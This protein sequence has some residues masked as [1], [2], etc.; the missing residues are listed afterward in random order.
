MADVTKTFKGLKKDGN[1]ALVHTGASFETKDASTVQQLSPLTYLG[2]GTIFEL[3]IPSNAAEI[4]L[5]PSTDLKISEDP[6]MASYWTCKADLPD[7]F[8][9][10]NMDTLYFEAVSS[11]GAL[12]FTFIT[13]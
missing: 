8:G 11:G 1:N 7:G 2:V 10:T 5:R 3:K 13:I 4:I 6:T 9:V 12:E